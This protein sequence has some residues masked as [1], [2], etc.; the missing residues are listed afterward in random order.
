M[1]FNLLIVTMFESKNLNENKTTVYS[2]N[3]HASLP[4]LQCSERC[5]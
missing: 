2:N 1:K 4:I 5:Q 3:L